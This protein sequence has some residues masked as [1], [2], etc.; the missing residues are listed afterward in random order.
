MIIAITGKIG[1]GKTAV[2]EIFAKEGYMVINADEIG[3]K[4]LKNLAIKK[5]LIAI[6]GSK[7]LTF[8]NI[9]RKKLGDIVFTDFEKLQK[10][11]E[12]IHPKII[13]EI[14]KIIDTNCN[15][16]IIIEAALYDKLQIEI[17]SDR[18]ILVK[19]DKDIIFER[20]KNRYNKEMI[21]NIY[22]SQD[23]PDESDFEIVNNK[24]LKDLKI[25][26]QDII[27]KLKEEN[28]KS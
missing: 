27:K 5:K 2:S 8:N 16:D 3:H 19:N 10:L 4:L 13:D 9:D 17:F 21:E 28:K 11:N 6:F 26:T 14:K 24:T 25:I 20:V 1:S 15:K 12:I 7:I 23:E 22:K 18:L